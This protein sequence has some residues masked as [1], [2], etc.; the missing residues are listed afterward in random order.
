MYHGVIAED[1][2][3]FPHWSHMPVKM[4]AWQLEYIKKHY[5]VM[6]LEKTILDIKQNKPLPQNVAIITFD[7][8]NNWT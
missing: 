8:G 2:A 5:N 1:L 6:P 4:F 3:K 7:D